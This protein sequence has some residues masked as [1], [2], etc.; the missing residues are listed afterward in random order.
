LILTLN[1][2]LEIHLNRVKV[3]SKQNDNISPI[4]VEKYLKGADYPADKENLVQQAKNNEATAEV[5]N[6]INQ[7]PEQKYHSPID[8]SKAV[9]QIEQ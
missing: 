1:K 9:G 7:L 3:M 8:V 4:A 6:I 5:I 2:S